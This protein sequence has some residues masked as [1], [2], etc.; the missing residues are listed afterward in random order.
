MQSSSSSWEENGK[1]RQSL[2][3]KACA[4]L[5][6]QMTPQKHKAGNSIRK[7]VLIP[8]SVPSFL[9]KSRLRVILVTFEFDEGSQWQD[10]D[11]DPHRHKENQLKK[12]SY[13]EPLADSARGS[14]NHRIVDVGRDLCRIFCPAPLLKQDHLDPIAQYQVQTGFDYLQ[15]WRLYKLFGQSVPVLGH[16]QIKKMSLDVQRKPPEFQVV[17]IASGPVTGRH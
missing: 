17:P 1:I 4:L 3:K 9:N 7:S 8:T 5:H 2:E 10:A 6:A 11:H 16:S 15:A 13:E 12:L 14:Q